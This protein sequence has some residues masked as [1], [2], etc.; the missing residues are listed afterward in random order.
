MKAVILTL[1][2]VL[3]STNTFASKYA[4]EIST[5]GLFERQIGGEYVKRGDRHMTVRF[6]CDE[7][8]DL[9]NCTSGQLAYTFCEE[10]GE[11][12]ECNDL[13]AIN[14]RSF[15]LNGVK[16]N[17]LL[18][19][20]E[21]FDWALHPVGIV[22]TLWIASEIPLFIA[23]LPV[24]AAIDLITIPGKLVFGGTAS[25]VRRIAINRRLRKLLKSVNENTT[26]SKTI[27]ERRFKSL[28]HL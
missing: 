26:F 20:G 12:N 22:G 4:G 21:F 23:L 10:R 8:Q 11:N 28:I 9:D 1:I 25:L 15:K 17:D 27:N 24:G 6:Y 19:S 14:I 5:D 2:T 16:A 18:R 13:R 7:G 3:L